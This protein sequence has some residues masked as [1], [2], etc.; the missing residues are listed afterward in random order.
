MKKSLKRRIKEDIVGWKDEVFENIFQD[1]A[2]I[3]LE[4]GM[5]EEEILNSLELV[6]Y[7]SI[8]NYCYADE[9][10]E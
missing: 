7:A 6:Y 4:H 8:N 10:G 9:E 3:M 5:T 1:T 2:N